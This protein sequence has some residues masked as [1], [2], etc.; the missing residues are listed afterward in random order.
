MRIFLC[1]LIVLML[2]GCGPPSAP[3][4]YPE[5]YTSLPSLGTSVQ[6][7]RPELG[8]VCVVSDGAYSG[9]IS[10]VKE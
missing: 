1:S 8:L 6:V 4:Q 10:C 7:F 3:R 9:G 2:V 5:G